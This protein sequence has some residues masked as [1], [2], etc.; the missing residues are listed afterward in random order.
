MRVVIDARPLSH[1]Q[2]GGYRSYTRALVQGLA[3]LAPR[4]IEVLLYLDRP[5]EM[6]VGL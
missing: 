1:P 2:A 5:I 4:D 6:R 3:E